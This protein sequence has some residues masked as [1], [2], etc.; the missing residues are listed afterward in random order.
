MGKGDGGG[1]RGLLLHGFVG[2]LGI[3][4]CVMLFIVRCRGIS[5]MSDWSSRRQFLRHAGAAGLGVLAGCGDQPNSPRAT[6]TPSVIPGQSSTS[7]EPDIVPSTPSPLSD[8][9]PPVIESYKAAATT[10]AGELSVSLAASDN[11]ALGR[12]VIRTSVDELETVLDGQQ[13]SL[14]T[15]VTASPGEV[16]QIQFLLEDEAGNRKKE[17]TESYVRKYNVLED[18]RLDIGAVYIPFA[19]AIEN[20]FERPEWARAPSVGQYPNPIPPEITSRHIDQMTG[21]G[22]N[23][24]IYSVEGTGAAARRQLDKFLESELLEQAIVQPLIPWSVFRDTMDESWKEDVLPDYASLVRDRL[25]S[26]EI[27]SLREGRPVVSTWS[28]RTFASGE[29]REK[30]MDEWGSY[31][32]FIHDFRTRLAVNGKDPYLVGG[33]ASAGMG[34]AY[35]VPRIR[36]LAIQFDAVRNWTARINQHRG[37]TYGWEQ[38]L[39]D[40][41]A[42]FRGTQEFTDANG[43]D[44]IPTVFPGFDDRGN[45]CWGGDRLIPRSPHRFNQMLEL[46]EEYASTDR[47]NIYSWNEWF[48]GSQIEPGTHRGNRYGTSYLEVVKDFQQGEDG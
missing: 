29:E 1:V 48:E 20:C 34:S 10:T 46:A 13:G 22:I 26:R 16:E 42:N 14:K 23:R 18:T 35:Q 8:S 45:T 27:I 5:A 43:M 12:A 17:R 28:F 36:D 39:S 38:V 33:M 25:L 30:V 19:G 9:I 40:V 15:R 31:E 32:A 21:Y 44:F 4:V 24:A 47:V 6:G 2:L 11:E 41:E 7:T 37:E 3:G